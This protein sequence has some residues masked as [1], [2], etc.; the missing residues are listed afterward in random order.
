MKKIKRLV[1]GLLVSVM[2]ISLTIQ[3]IP[4]SAAELG[5]E[6]DNVLISGESGV[7]TSG[8][9]EVGI[10]EDDFNSIDNLD[11]KNQLDESEESDK[12][13]ESD[14]DGNTADSE[15]TADSEGTDQA[16]GSDEDTD[17][18]DDTE[19]TGQTDE[20]DETDDSNSSGDS[21]EEGESVLI[22]SE[23][24]EWDKCQYII[25]P[26]NRSGITY[27]IIDSQLFIPIE[28]IAA[29]TIYAVNTSAAE[30]IEFEA[31]VA[32]GYRLQ[33]SDKLESII[34][35]NGER[36]SSNGRWIYNYTIDTSELS[37]T[38]DRPLSVSLI[39]TV[40]EVSIHVSGDVLVNGVDENGMA[41]IG[42]V[43]SIEA[44]TAGE[45]IAMITEDEEGNTVYTAMELDYENR[46]IFTVEK[47]A[48][49]I[50]VNPDEVDYVI[51]NSSTN[52]AKLT[53]EAGLKLK[54][55]ASSAQGYKEIVLNFT[56][57]PNG[58]DGTATESAYY[59]VKV[60]AAPKKNETIPSGSPGSADEPDP[61]Y[62]YIKKTAD[63]NTQSK[64]IIVNDGTGENTACTYEFSVRLV[65]I[66]NNISV[67]N[68]DTPRKEALETVLSGNTIVKSFATKNLYY[69]EK[70]GFTKKTTN[71]Y[72][73]QSDVLAGTVKYSKKASYLHDLTAV[74]Y[75]S[76]GE[77]CTNISCY[78]KND[79]DE[80]YISANEYT[81]PGKY[82]VT[83]FAG[84][85]DDSVVG[86]P[87]S[88]TMYQANVSFT[89]TVLAGI[90][91]ITTSSITKRVAITD[92][93]VTFSAVPV[94]YSGYGYKSKTQRFTYE[95]KSAVKDDSSY[96][97]FRTVE[98]IDRVKNSISVNKNGKVTIK[99]G[100]TVDATTG[101]D[102][103]AIVIKAAD[104]AGN[105]AEATAYVRITNTVL[106]PTDIYLTDSNGNRLSTTLTADK[107]HSAR[108][109][110][111]DQYGNN[112]L[113]HVTLTPKDNAKGT[114]S[115]YINNSG[116]SA[117]LYVRKTGTITIKAVST[118]GGKKS[119]TVKINVTSPS[120]PSQATYYY[121][122]YDFIT[123]NGAVINDFS[124]SNNGRI[125]YRAPKGAVIKFRQGF[126]INGKDYYSRGWWDW[127]YSVTG[128]KLKFDNDYWLL[129]PTAKTA[130]L[131]IWLKSNPSRKWK[132]DIINNAWDT[133]YSTPKLKLLSGK[134]YNNPYANSSDVIYYDYDD[135]YYYD[136]P[137][138]QLTYLY[139][140]VDCDSIRITAKSKSAPGVWV[141]DLNVTAKTFKL[142]F[143]AYGLKAGSYKYNV[144]FYKNGALIGKPA[145]ITVKI[146][147]SSKLKITSSYTLNTGQAD[148]VILKCTPNEFIPDYDT[149]LLNA[150]VGGR[151]NDFN[152]YF[153]LVTSTNSDGITTT[154][155]KFKDSVT[156]EEKAAL[157][158]KTLTGYVKYSYYLG[159]NHIENATSKIS[160]KIK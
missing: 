142:N 90:N 34:S 11:G 70:L 15:D 84:I 2:V 57:V 131:E 110:V 75:N 52:K 92:K 100:Y 13:D 40:S 58:S 109:V 45:N 159:Y 68:E 144:A 6:T 88:G 98:P 120:A 61:R 143:G 55:L 36:R 19:G 103:I 124:T 138:Q 140:S 79:N 74:V 129:T 150:N 39:K 47:A 147:K 123:Y 51:A 132:L 41:Q 126:Q 60:I 137:N 38:V 8:S 28:G 1:S 5:I 136:L 76:G 153:E 7:L 139:E 66:S 119:T 112:M 67:P 72:T 44:L 107:A 125:Q 82:T 104:F 30:E 85:G 62:Y 97:G 122:Q 10:G 22:P 96:S 23:I 17:V 128:G 63:V 148:S 87:Q 160:I 154:S 25:F 3:E 73:G 145:T 146:N 65:H 80:L 59:E 21:A 141:S 94:G 83:V 43:V 32:L 108:V 91:Y 93:S 14:E 106:V 77:I 4:V 26:D 42:S 115:A 56:A 18:T 149:K 118:D 33:V 99:K 130:T 135:Y 151:E 121:S 127:G 101:E 89:L 156:S 116:Y 113:G 111:L 31:S 157:K 155:I 49:F 35:Q 134:L 81:D 20:S 16:D 54:S 86:N 50:A 46:Y 27:D 117:Y 102:Y 71:I 114:A 78:F 37:S 152:T 48:S 105:N 158:G 9:D 24:Q 29:T 64:S 69:E 12:T 53:G 95:V 133:S